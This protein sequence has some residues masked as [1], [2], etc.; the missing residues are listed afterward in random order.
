MYILAVIK[1]ENICLLVTE[2][3]VEVIPGKDRLNVHGTGILGN[4]SG[5]EYEARDAG[6]ELL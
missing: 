4:F 1:N 5:P 3:K 2:K 6:P